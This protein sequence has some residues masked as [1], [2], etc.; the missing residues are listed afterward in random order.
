MN[1]GDVERN[2]LTTKVTK[3]LHKDHKGLKHNVSTLCPFRQLADGSTP[4]QPLRK[5]DLITIHY[6]HTK[7]LN[8]IIIF[9]ADTGC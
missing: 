6:M 5:L 3:G 4:V 1:T 9:T 2:P 7:R 8:K